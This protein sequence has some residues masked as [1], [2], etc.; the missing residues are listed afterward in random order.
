MTMNA[1]MAACLT[2]AWRRICSWVDKPLRLCTCSIRLLNM[3]PKNDEAAVESEAT[4]LTRDV[5]QQVHICIVLQGC[6]AFRP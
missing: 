4:G 1:D 3:T 6:K 2:L 5:K